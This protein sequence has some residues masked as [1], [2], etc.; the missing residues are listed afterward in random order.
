MRTR[1]VHR[2][3]GSPS[4][5]MPKHGFG[6][7]VIFRVCLLLAISKLGNCQKKNSF[8]KFAPSLSAGAGGA[9]SVGSRLRLMSMGRRLSSM[10]KSGSPL[11]RRTGT[12]GVVAPAPAVSFG[13]GNSSRNLSRKASS[14]LRW[15]ESAGNLS[16]KPS[17]QTGPVAVQLSKE[18]LSTWRLAL[19]RGL[20]FGGDD[21]SPSQ[22]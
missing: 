11:T 5:C 18:R 13:G 14:S 4:S 7:K 19:A 8:Q 10:V 17:G 21:G 6:E 20:V 1:V 9:S 3:T 2:K 12:L 16:V 15:A 22:C